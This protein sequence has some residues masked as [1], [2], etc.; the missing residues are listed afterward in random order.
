MIDNLALLE[1]FKDFALSHNTKLIK[2]GKG[3]KCACPI[4]GDSKNGNKQRLNVY[5]VKG[6]YV[7]NCFNGGCPVSNLSLYK[8]LKK[9]HNVNLKPSTF[10]STKNSP[11][12]LKI[13]D[14]ENTI[15]DKFYDSE[16]RE[17]F[18]KKFNKDYIKKTLQELKII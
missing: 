8:F 2:Q 1:L 6:N 10:V 12:L 4:C 17:N 11:T 18:I 13:E 9:Y 7:V 15:Y 16:F 5:E 14:V 3:Y